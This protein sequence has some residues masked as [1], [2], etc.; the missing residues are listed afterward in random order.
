MRTG[1]TDAVSGN[2]L[3]PLRAEEEAG[4][5]GLFPGTGETVPGHRLQV[6][7]NDVIKVT[8]LRKLMMRI[9]RIIRN[10][11][12]DGTTRSTQILLNPWRITEGGKVWMKGG[13]ATNGLSVTPTAGVRVQERTVLEVLMI[14]IMG[15]TA[16]P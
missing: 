14:Y 4:E 11:R 15:I 9:I 2:R 16:V 7:G 10:L 12:V 3:P 13:L 5:V 1:E 6:P 8:P